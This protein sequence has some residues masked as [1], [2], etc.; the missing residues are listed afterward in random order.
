MINVES[1]PDIKN[2]ISIDVP[3]IKPQMIK[4]INEVTFCSDFFW[5][6]DFGCNYCII[7][8]FYILNTRKH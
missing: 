3:I 2:A 7:Q 1:R 6:G 4:I 5:G 8:Y